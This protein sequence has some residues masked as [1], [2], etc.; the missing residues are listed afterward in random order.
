MNIW[1]LSL[2]LALPAGAQTNPQRAQ[3]RSTLFVPD[4]LPALAPNRTASLSLLPA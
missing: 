2:L 4:P 1:L 3:I